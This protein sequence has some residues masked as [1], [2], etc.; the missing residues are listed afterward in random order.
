M[1]VITALLILVTIALGVLRNFP[2]SA[3][4]YCYLYQA[5]TM[6]EGRLWND[7]HPLEPFF[8]FNYIQAR[9]GKL[10]G[11]FPPGWPLVLAATT[12]LNVPSWLVNPAL[13][14][15]SLFVLFLIGRRMYD[16]STALI[17]IATTFISGFFLFNAASYFSHTFCGLLILVG[18]YCSHRFLSEGRGWQ[19]MLAGAVFAAALLT[20]YY[21]AFLSVLPLVAWVVVRARRRGALVLWGLLGALPFAGFLL[22]YDQQLTGHPFQLSLS[23]VELASARWLAP[24]FPG[25]AVDITLCSSSVSCCGRRRACSSSTPWPCGRTSRPGGSRRLPCRSASRSSA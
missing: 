18:V 23:G 7:P 17:A 4:E 21:S 12:L 14:V 22:F 25:R 9:D 11:V 15:A 24:G 10:F 20:R 6:A 19:I 1:G 13:G 8:T 3:D 2:N 5:R 16:E